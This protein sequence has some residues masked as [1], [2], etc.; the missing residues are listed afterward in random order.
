MSQRQAK[1]DRRPPRVIFTGSGRF[2][3]EPARTAARVPPRGGGAAPS[4]ATIGFYGRFSSVGSAATSTEKWKHSEP[5]GGVKT[6]RPD[7][8]FM[9]Y[10]RGI[11]PAH[12][13]PE[14]L[15]RVGSSGLIAAP[16]AYS[17][18][19]KAKP[20]PRT[21]QDL[22]YTLPSS[23]GE[24]AVSHRATPARFSRTS[25]VRDS[26][27][28]P[29]SLARNAAL[30]TKVK[31]G[32]SLDREEREELRYANL[33]EPFEENG[34]VA[35]NT[36]NPPSEFDGG[37]GGG[38]LNPSQSYAFGSVLSRPR[39]PSARPSERQS[40]EGERRGE[41]SASTSALPHG[42]RMGVAFRKDPP[43]SPG[44]CDYP[45]DS[46]FD[47]TG[48]LR[49]SKSQ[50]AFS[51]SPFVPFEKMAGKAMEVPGACTYFIE[52]KFERPKS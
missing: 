42:G 51:I 35:F 29:S 33:N 45:K 21:S 30:R 38:S 44:P 8:G 22:M 9:A 31:K 46:G 36:F 41:R 24:Q 34:S 11:G 25:E 13:T 2:G 43:V 1:A 14:K 52:P 7:A 10:Q 19:G 6:R 39:F 18:L 20:L 27:R 4:Y 48:R 40:D 15:S 23:I 3:D 37:S 49:L 50:P 47:G 32:Q 16:P 5:T 12:Y 17:I 28:L 26:S